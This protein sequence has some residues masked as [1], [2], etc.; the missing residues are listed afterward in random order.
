MSALPWALLTPGRFPPLPHPS[1]STCCAA[2]IL[3]AQSRSG[4][5]PACAL[6]GSGAGKGTAWCPWLWRSGLRGSQLAIVSCAAA[7]PEPSTPPV[8]IPRGTSPRLGPQIVLSVYGPDVFGNDVV[9]GYGAV[10]LPFSPGRHKRTIPMF[11]PESTSKLQKFTSWFMGRRPEYTDPKVVA[12]G[13]GREVTRVRSQGFVTLLFN[14]VTKDMRKLGYD[15]GPSDTQG[16]SGPSPP[17]GR[18]L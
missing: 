9:R 8:H 10:H 2:D 4:E 12:Q 6:D 17:P 3:G 15:T 1:S 16:V 5:A 11:V 7:R 18:P 13:E 14:V